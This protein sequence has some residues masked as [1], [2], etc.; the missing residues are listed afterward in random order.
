[1]FQETTEHQLKSLINTFFLPRV[2]LKKCRQIEKKMEWRWTHPCVNE[3][4]VS[5]QR[6]KKQLKRIP[7]SSEESN[8]RPTLVY[9]VAN[10]SDCIGADF[11]TKNH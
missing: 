7:R 11:E 9:D 6:V 1:M 3:M 10:E 5:W 4:M 2:E 8:P